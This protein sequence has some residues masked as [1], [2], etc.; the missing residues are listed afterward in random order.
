M[1]E[2]ESVLSE[3]YMITTMQSA[4]AQGVRDHGFLL[5]SDHENSPGR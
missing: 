1:I 4:T 2:E 5:T 3:K